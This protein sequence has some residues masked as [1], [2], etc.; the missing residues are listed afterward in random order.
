MRACAPHVELLRCHV[1]RGSRHLDAGQP[2][3]VEA[4]RDAEIE[5]HRLVRVGGDPDVRRLDV[6]VDDA[7]RMRVLER[8][9][10]LRHHRADALDACRAWQARALEQE[11]AQVTSGEVVHH[12]VGVAGEAARAEDADD[13]G[14]TELGEVPDLALEACLEQHAAHAAAPDLANE[15]VGP[16]DRSGRERVGA[17]RR[18]ARLDVRQCPRAQNFFAWQAL[19]LGGAKLRSRARGFPQCANARATRRAT[20]AAANPQVWRVAGPPVPQH[21]SHPSVRHGCC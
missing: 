15:L 19:R 2:H 1:E 8:P 12:Q 17:V 11:L 7:V 14:V 13:A 18:H 16:D 21:S 6:A 4:L 20:Q 10:D 3:V 5:Q 9:R